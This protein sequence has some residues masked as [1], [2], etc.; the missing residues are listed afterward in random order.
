MSQTDQLFDN[1]E[2]TALVNIYRT[3]KKA[4]KNGQEALKHLAMLTG[5]SENAVYMAIYRAIK[6]EHD[7]TQADLNNSIN[8]LAKEVQQS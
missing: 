8:T 4:K 2:K 1:Q 5:K 6:E 3:Y 7:T